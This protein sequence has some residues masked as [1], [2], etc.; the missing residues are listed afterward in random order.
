MTTKIQPVAK[1]TLGQEIDAVTAGLHARISALEAKASTDE[2]KV[3][4]WVK[5]NWPHAVTWV[6]GAVMALKAFGKL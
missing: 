4:A 3:V 5:T 1:A 6:G 2:Q